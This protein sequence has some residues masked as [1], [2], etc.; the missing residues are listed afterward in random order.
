[1]CECY[2]IHSIPLRLCVF[3]GVEAINCPL[4]SMHH[5]GSESCPSGHYAKP[6]HKPNPTIVGRKS[7]PSR[8]YLWEM[9]NRECFPIHGLLNHHTCLKP[10]GS[11]CVCT[12]SPMCSTLNCLT[13]NSTIF[14]LDSTIKIDGSI[15]GKLY[16]DNSMGQNKER[17][18]IS[19]LTKGWWPIR[20]IDRKL[21]IATMCRS[22]SP[23]HKMDC[24]IR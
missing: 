2:A 17:G 22:V 3:A 19:S 21:N 6:N 4:Y 20:T 13:F 10:R 16:N 11:P 15:T 12:C 9:W 7:H 24:W 23:N 18:V 1:M 8:W 5:R 14:Q